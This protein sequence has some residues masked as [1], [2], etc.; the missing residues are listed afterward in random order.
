M[1]YA[2]E[3]KSTTPGSLFGGT[4][5]REASVWQVNPETGELHRILEM[6]R[7][8]VPA[9]LN[10]PSSNEIGNW[11]SSGVID[12]T[13]LFPTVHNETLLLLNVEAHSLQGEALGGSNQASD[14]VEGGQILFA[15]STNRANAISILPPN[16]GRG[17]N[18]DADD[19]HSLDAGS[20]TAGLALRVGPNPTTSATNVGFAIAEET[21]V[22]VSVYD[23]SGRQVRV[24][25][26][27]RRTAGEHVL[28]WDGRNGNGQD[29]DSGV[30]FIRLSTPTGADEAKVSVLR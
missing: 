19:V 2:Q 18:G 7:S 29:V 26:Q 25:A 22:S 5:G 16:G 27:G 15:S 14:L 11:E 1:I 8:A 28:V 24:L 13:D 30:Y 9:G 3:D 4:S 12:V 23:A 20:L 17:L 6:D 21:E 10:D